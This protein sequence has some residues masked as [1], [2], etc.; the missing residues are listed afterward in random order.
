[1]RG[2]KQDARWNRPR[3]QRQQLIYEDVGYKDQET[4]SAAPRSQQRA[5]S[6]GGLAGLA[7]GQTISPFAL[8]NA[9]TTVFSSGT[10]TI[11]CAQG[12]NHEGQ[13][14]PTTRNTIDR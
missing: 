3:K 7:L 4:A 12:A 10:T 2:Q 6:V 13:V 5:G 9:T 1:M 8:P 14:Q 11:T